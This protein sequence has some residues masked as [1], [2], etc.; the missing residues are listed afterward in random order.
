MPLSPRAM[1]QMFC[2]SGAGADDSREVQR[3]TGAPAVPP[4]LEPTR[5]S[6]PDSP[7]AGVV[8]RD[9][10][11]AT[12]DQLADEVADELRRKLQSQMRLQIDP[13]APLGLRGLP[14]HFEQMLTVSGFTREEV[15]ANAPD[16]LDM[17]RFEEERLGASFT[18]KDR[19]PSVR[20]YPLEDM[21][22]DGDPTQEYSDL[23]LLDTGAQGQ[24][25]S[26]VSRSGEPVALKKIKLKEDPKERLLFETEISMLHSCRHPNVVELRACHLAHSVLWI[27]MELMD[28]KL[29]DL[30][31]GGVQFSA[32]QIGFLMLEVLKGLEYLHSTGRIHRDVKSDNVLVSADGKVKLGDFGLCALVSEEERMRKTIVGTPY[33]MAPE[34]IRGK[35]YDGKADVW[36]LGIVGLE[37]C[38]G[39]PPHLRL[40]VMR[41]LYTIARS[42]APKVRRRDSWPSGLLDFVEAMLVKDVQRRP[43]S[44]DLLRQPFLRSGGAEGVSDPAAF[45]TAALHRA[46]AKGGK[47]KP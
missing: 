39:E 45:L 28:G 40:P 2:S 38:D 23:R 25:F 19:P 43:S 1:L 8:V 29:T 14:Y 26:A 35:E 13:G 22:A 7:R 4:A 33:W 21:V 17:I 24:V 42:P 37:L 11:G 31:L 41:A 12:V 30:I 32:G 16:V 34:I 47:R 44:S 15:L 9:T 10:A 5:I 6:D 18:R 27:G 46:R 36:S 20:C 3:R